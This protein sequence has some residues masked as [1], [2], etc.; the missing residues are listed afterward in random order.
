MLGKM[1]ADFDDEHVIE[2]ANQYCK[3]ERARKG[4][5]MDEKQPFVMPLEIL[6]GIWS[7]DGKYAS[8]DGILHSWRKSGILPVTWN[9]DINASL[10]CISVP[11]KVKALSIEDCNELCNM[12]TRLQVNCASIDT[13]FTALADSAAVEADVAAGGA[14]DSGAV[15]IRNVVRDETVRCG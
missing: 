5:H 9:Q 11:M 10:G 2:M 14:G 13:L 1:L 4:W 12:M 15:P 8:N 7:Q 6:G 3:R